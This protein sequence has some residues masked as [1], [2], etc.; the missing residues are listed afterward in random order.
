LNPYDNFVR[1]N[2]IRDQFTFTVESTGALSAMN[3]VSV[4]L[5]VLSEKLEDL[6]RII[7]TLVDI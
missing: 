6:K 2:S 4:A 7:S 1:V 5:K 3:I